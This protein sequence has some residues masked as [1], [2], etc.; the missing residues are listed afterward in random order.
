MQV[1]LFG[2]ATYGLPALAAPGDIAP[3]WIAGLA[4]GLGGLVGGYAGA[5]PQPRLPERALRLLPGILAIGL[6]LLY[7]LQAAA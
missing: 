1:D 6:A 4:C 7:L 3:N 2:A 5:R